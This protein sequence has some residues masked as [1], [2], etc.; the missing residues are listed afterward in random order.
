MHVI[1]VTSPLLIYGILWCPAFK[2]GYTSSDSTGLPAFALKGFPG[3]SLVSL[4]AFAFAG[5]A[6]SAL[7]ASAGMAFTPIAIALV[8]RL[9]KGEE[10]H[11]LSEVHFEDWW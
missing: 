9:A 6:S 10:R 4:P 7:L 11:D 3:S 8:K 5:P 1:L 2:V